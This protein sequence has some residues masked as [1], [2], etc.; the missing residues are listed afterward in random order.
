M[1]EDAPRS[2]RGQRLNP[3]VLPSDTDLRFVLLIISVLG[4][5]LFTYN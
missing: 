4:A 5:S 3:F 2:L 1:A